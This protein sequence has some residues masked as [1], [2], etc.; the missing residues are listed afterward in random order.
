MNLLYRSVIVERLRAALSAARTV[1]SL[2][3]QGVKGAIR[4]VLIGDLFRP[5]LPADIG[6]ETGVLI[7]G[8]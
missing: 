7:F 6:I 5:M 3:H 4:A 2:E 1:Q 8:G